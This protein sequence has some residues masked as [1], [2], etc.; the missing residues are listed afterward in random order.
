MYI[1]EYNNSQY[2]YYKNTMCYTFS[3]HLEHLF[4]CARQINLKYEIS[5]SIFIV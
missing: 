2:K 1:F 5:L 3:I 4:W